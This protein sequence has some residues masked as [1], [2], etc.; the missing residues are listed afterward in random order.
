MKNKLVVFGVSVVLM[1]SIALSASADT[2]S[3]YIQS[4]G[5]TVGGFIGSQS[6]VGQIVP[7]DG[8]P[9]VSEPIKTVI[10]GN[11]QIIDMAARLLDID[12]DTFLEMVKRAGI[13]F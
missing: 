2:G 13:R 12:R 6:L 9:T 7:L 1:G 10:S 8:I 11:T 3:S 5:R 4:N